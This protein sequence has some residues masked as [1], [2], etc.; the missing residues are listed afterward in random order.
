[1]TVSAL[2]VKLMEREEPLKDEKL[3]FVDGLI[4]A[5]MQFEVPV[6]ALQR[7]FNLKMIS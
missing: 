3:Q 2:Q 6:Y 7:I 5:L 4:N 1:M